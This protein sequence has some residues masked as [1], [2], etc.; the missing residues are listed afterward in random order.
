MNSDKIKGYEIYYNE[1]HDNFLKIM[2]ESGKE[3]HF[4][5]SGMKVN[6]LNR[7]KDNSYYFSEDGKTFIAEYEHPHDRDWDYCLIYEDLVKHGSRL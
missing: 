5:S 4:A 3:E 2:Y 1:N 6:V 7:Q